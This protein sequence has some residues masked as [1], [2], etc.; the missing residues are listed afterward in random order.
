[1]ITR[2]HAENKNFTLGEYKFGPVF[3][4]LCYELDLED[5]AVELV[6]DKVIYC[7]SVP[8]PAQVIWSSQLLE[9]TSFHYIFFF[10]GKTF[11]LNK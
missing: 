2:Y 9:D 8:S 1:M 11:R 10:L 4:R 5:S 7:F 6:R 3:M